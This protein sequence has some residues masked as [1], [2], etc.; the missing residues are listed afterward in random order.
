M[1]AK[2]FKWIKLILKFS[3]AFFIIGYMVY[4]GRLD[5]SV[6]RTGLSHVGIMISCLFL[7][8][9]ATTIGLYRWR[10]LLRGQGIVF[11]VG[12]IF[13]YG[14]I[15]CFFNTTMPGA[16]SGDIIKAW[17]VISENKGHDKTPVLTS[18]LL[19]R[20]MG[21]FGI[22][23]VSFVPLA[24]SWREA[25]ASPQLHGVAMLVSALALGMFCFFFYI[26]F[27]VYGPFAAIRR[28]MERLKGLPGGET[29]LK[30]YDA[31]MSYREHPEVLFQS[32]VLSVCTHV[33]IV[34]AII[35]CSLALGDNSMGLYQYFL[36]A[37][38]GLIT[39]AIPIA[40]GG[41]G[42]GHMAFQ[43]LFK[44]AGSSHGAEIFTLY[45]MLQIFVNLSGVFFYLRAP[46]VV[47]AT[48]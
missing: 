26:M 46:K 15:G 13:R 12:H 3:L 16:V 34:T 40:P 18:I 37:P 44:L 5:L 43:G 32:L 41:L 2:A 6:V 30:A 11:P 17:Y 19:D 21:V 22:I 20:A 47:A 48:E 31:F 35:F 7:V 24:F 25:W 39:T 29:F 42:V 28:A 23:I 38:V 27:S 4:T 33:S 45:V 14:L 9:L 36:L 10:L 8:I 1:R